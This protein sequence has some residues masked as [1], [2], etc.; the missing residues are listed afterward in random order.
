[1]STVWREAASN[2]WEPLAV[3][4]GRPLDGADLGVPGL[5]VFRFGQGGDRGVGLL[6]RA[7]TAAFVNGEPLLGRF[8]VLE[9]KDEV[10]VGRLRL[11][12]SSESAPVVAVFRAQPAARPCTC[13]VCRGV[14][15]DGDTA[16]QCPGCSRWFHQL[17]AAEGRP[18]RR[19]WSFAAQCRICNHPTA[20]TGEP[21]WRP[22]KEEA[23]V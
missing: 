14:L 15:K 12:F 17:E 23:H 19:C 20:L 3:P 21:V 5:R 6:V 9:H 4:E 11:Y 2:R 1:M 7:G 18:A 13:P 16:V 22:E 10:L 8:R